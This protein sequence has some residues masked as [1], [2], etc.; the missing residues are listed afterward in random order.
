MGESQTT[1]NAVV[2]IVLAAGRGNRLGS[3]TSKALVPIC[4]KPLIVHQLQQFQAARIERV[5]VVTNSASTKRLVEIGRSMASSG[6]PAIEVITADTRTAFESLI[7]GLEWGGCVESIAS[8]VDSLTPK[9]TMS[10]LAVLHRN[11]DAVVGVART[12]LIGDHL[13]VD[14]DDNDAVVRLGRV[15]I[16][17]DLVTA[18]CLRLSKSISSLA[19]EAWRA[20]VVTLTGFQQHLAR[21]QRL[22]SVKLNWVLDI[23]LPEDRQ[24]AE[25]F[26]T[27]NL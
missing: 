20:G 16:R 6:G 3:H 24:A 5:A 9:D 4:G 22:D 10:R 21:A 23:D 2:G 8:C 17:S 25:S 11:A 15:R 14:I 12:P 26:L 18:G 27:N 1:M 7:T 19:Q 13:W